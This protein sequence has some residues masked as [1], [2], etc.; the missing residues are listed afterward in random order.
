MLKLYEVVWFCPENG[1]VDS[2]RE[3]VYGF[4]GV[5]CLSH[6]VRAGCQ[7]V[8]IICIR[9]YP[10]LKS[11]T[12]CIPVVPHKAVAEVSKIGNL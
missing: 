6:S 3:Q 11:V 8:C 7:K 9:L 5:Q 12:V 1:C 2:E 10:T 4:T